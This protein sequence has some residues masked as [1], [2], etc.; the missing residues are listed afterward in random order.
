MIAATCLV[1]IIIVAVLGSV[2]LLVSHRAFVLCLWLALRVL[3]A[4]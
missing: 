1:L 3:V 2:V 4:R